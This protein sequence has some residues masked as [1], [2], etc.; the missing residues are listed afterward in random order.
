MINT[1]NT[2]TQ[3]LLR[4]STEMNTVANRI[5][6][7]TLSEE[8]PNMTNKEVIQQK[9]KGIESLQIAIDK[10]VNY[11][12]VLKDMT[13]LVASFAELVQQ[14]IKQMGNVETIDIAMNGIIDD[15][16]MLQNAKVVDTKLFGIRTELVID[17]GMKVVRTFDRSIVQLRGTDISTIM[18]DMIE[19]PNMDT[20]KEIQE[21]LVNSQT[22]VG[23]SHALAIQTQDLFELQKTAMENRNKPDFVKDMMELNRLQRQYEVI[24]LTIRETSDT[25]LINFLV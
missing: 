16:E 5:S 3:S 15:F 14:K 13:K 1:L 10:Y 11:D 22:Q 12:N 25:S 2:L 4:T 18:R 8:T 7:G 23:V 24:A 6:Q 20:V 9:S 17:D 21:K 19:R